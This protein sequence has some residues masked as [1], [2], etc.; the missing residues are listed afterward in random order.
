MYGGTFDPVH[1]G[2]LLL[3]ESCREQARLNEVRFIPAALP[4]HKQDQHISSGE[5]R[6]NMLKL[7]LG[8]YPEFEVSDR[9]LQRKG[10][11]YTVTTLEELALETPNA[12]LF[13]LMGADSLLEF[14]TWKDPLRIMELA[15][16]L[17]VG[18]GGERPPDFAQVFSESEIQTAARE[19]VRFVQ[20]PGCQL[21][22]TEIRRR[23]LEG[24]SI[25]F[26]TPAAVEKYIE[27][28]RLYR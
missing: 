23:A 5:D 24:K 20:M 25:R 18:R 8:G 3:A 11:S 10:P 14:P 21:S 2:H 9:E 1:Y 12:E 7:A 16:I 15:E 26:Q 28:H 22:S 13:L 27:T 4:P 17:V 19:R 6:L